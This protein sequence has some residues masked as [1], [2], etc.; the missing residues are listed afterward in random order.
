MLLWILPSYN[1]EHALPLVL[2]EIKSLLA[3][4]NLCVDVC[5]VDDGSS[6]RS[7]MILEDYSNEYPS[8]LHISHSINIGVSGVLLT[9]FKIALKLGY[10]FLI[11]CDADGQHPIQSIPDLLKIAR[12]RNHD[13]L[14][15]SRFFKSDA[16]ANKDSMQRI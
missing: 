15:G 16:K 8:I 10:D 4:S 11:Q 1:E 7:K 2:N 3:I 12:E 9:G 14:I 13:L 6:D 5:I